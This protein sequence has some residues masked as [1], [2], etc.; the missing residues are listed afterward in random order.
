MS[1][2][3]SEMQKEQK[4]LQAQL[5]ALLKQQNSS[6]PGLNSGTGV[7]STGLTNPNSTNLWADAPRRMLPKWPEPMPKIKS[8]YS[9]EYDTTLGASTKQIDMFAVHDE[10][11]L[12]ENQIASFLKNLAMN[13]RPQVK[14]YKPDLFE[15]FEKNFMAQQQQPQPNPPRQ[16][17]PPAPDLPN[18]NNPIFNPLLEP[19]Q[20]IPYL[21]IEVQNLI[22]T[23]ALKL[24]DKD[25]VSK[26]LEV[27]LMNYG[28][29]FSGL[30]FHPN[31]PFC[32]IFHIHRPSR[33]PVHA[34]VFLWYLTK[35]Y[36]VGFIFDA[37]ILLQYIRI[38][39]A[40]LE[41]RNIYG[42]LYNPTTA[43]GTASGTFNFFTF[44][45]WFKSIDQW[46]TAL[47]THHHRYCLI[48]FHGPM[49]IPHPDGSNANIVEWFPTNLAKSPK[50][51]EN[52]N[53]IR[54]RKNETYLTKNITVLTRDSHHLESLENTK[55]RTRNSSKNFTSMNLLLEFMRLPPDL[56]TMA[57]SINN[58]TT[59]ACKFRDAAVDFTD[60]QAVKWMA[61]ATSTGGDN[62]D[63][64]VDA[65]EA[66]QS[67][68]ELM[69]FL[70]KH[71]S[72]NTF[73]RALFSLNLVGAS[74]M[75]GRAP[76]ENVEALAM[77][78]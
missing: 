40:D 51:L 67:H 35:A 64:P 29:L 20:A 57:L 21:P 31:Y 77:V 34:L 15:N 19:M 50:E 1:S 70:R 18:P 73:R 42:E 61:K 76:K 33:V 13:D 26:F 32:S 23:H 45:Q 3:F 37:P 47:Q 24:R 69:T 49:R 12:P 17:P 65:K 60:C 39:T 27:T 62:F 11:S 54:Y 28:L 10:G 22:L 66:V 7:P 68:K 44:F 38:A 41:I 8:P 72:K 56:T 4:S 16:N 71:L 55:A 6:F 75:I 78:E 63:N 48:T 36:T 5:D 30:R 46:K 9:Q 58:H 2:Y 59:Q 43:R 14:A 52:A 74:A 53:Y 25:L